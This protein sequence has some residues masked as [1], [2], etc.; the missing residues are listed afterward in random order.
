MIYVI[1]S[2][3]HRFTIIARACLIKGNNVSCSELICR[4][5]LSVFFSKIRSIIPNIP[6]TRQTMKDINSLTPSFLRNTSDTLL[7]ESFLTN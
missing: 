5:T 1:F 4:R 2:L 6:F 3:Y 7:L